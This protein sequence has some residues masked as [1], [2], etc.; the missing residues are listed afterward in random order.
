MSEP[1]HLSSIRLSVNCGGLAALRGVSVSGDYGNVLETERVVLVNARVAAGFA[2][3]L[4][5]PIGRATNEWGSTV[6]TGLAAGEGW[7]RTLGPPASGMTRTFGVASNI[8]E[9]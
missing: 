3:P 8:I 2:V 7:I 5:K 4:V 6:R 1:Y 9:L